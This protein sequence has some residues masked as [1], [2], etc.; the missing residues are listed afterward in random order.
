[1]KELVEKEIEEQKYGQDWMRQYFNN[2]YANLPFG[3][4]RDYPTLTKKSKK[5]YRR[6]DKI[7]KDSGIDMKKIRRTAK[8]DQ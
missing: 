3:F 5:Q 1:M 4:I 2:F 7:V 6:I 8:G